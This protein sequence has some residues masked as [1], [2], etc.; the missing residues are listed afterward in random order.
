MRRPYPLLAPLADFL[1][2]AAQLRIAQCDRDAGQIA[3]FAQRRIPALLIEQLLD[4]GKVAG[5]HP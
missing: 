3:G 1:A 5:E 4:I 2:G